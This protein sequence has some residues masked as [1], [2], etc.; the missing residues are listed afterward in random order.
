MS[1]LPAT[2]EIKAS[3]HA[4]LCNLLHV[5]CP[6]LPVVW[7]ASCHCIASV[8]YLTRI[9]RLWKR[10]CWKLT[11]LGLQIRYIDY[12]QTIYRFDECDISILTR[13][14]GSRLRI[15]MLLQISPLDGFSVEAPKHRIIL[16]CNNCFKNALTIK[17]IQFEVLFRDILLISNID[18]ITLVCNKEITRRG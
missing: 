7:L 13:Q 15:R 2:V 6:I 8:C 10:T 11:D 5:T 1:H 18:N 16:K 9:R 14:I 12:V 4:T 17:L 3:F